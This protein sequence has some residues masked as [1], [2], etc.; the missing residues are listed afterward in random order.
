MAYHNEYTIAARIEQY[1]GRY[2]VVDG[3]SAKFWECLKDGDNPDKFATRWGAIKLTKTR[4]NTKGDMD[5]YQAAKKIAEKLNKG[6][7]MVQK[8]QDVMESRFA[9]EDAV[10]L[11][12]N[13][14][15]IPAPQIEEAA[16]PPPARRRL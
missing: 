7:K 11:Q 4:H 12:K 9:Q 10:A 1:L 14:A 5:L 6:Y 16:A 8:S 2:E 3:K 15:V 13:T